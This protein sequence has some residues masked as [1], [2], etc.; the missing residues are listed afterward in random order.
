MSFS[1]HAE[2]YPCDGGTIFSSVP[3]PIAVDE[4]PAGYS[5]AGCS[6]TEPA[7]ASP[8]SF[9]MLHKRPAG[10]LFH[11]VGEIKNWTRNASK[12]SVTFLDEATRGE[13]IVDARQV[14][15]EKNMA[16]LEAVAQAL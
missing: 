7:S 4:S 11:S 9:S 5:L 2:I 16:T 10:R 1:R 6:P 8:T 13:R 3:P 15:V 14:A 12:P